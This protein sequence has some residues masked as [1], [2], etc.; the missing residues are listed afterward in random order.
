M[1]NLAESLSVRDQRQPG[2]FHVDNEI[3]DQYG[4]KLGAYGVAVYCVLSRHAKR[5]DERVNLS[6]RDVAALLGISQDRVR[7]SLADLAEAGLIDLQ[8]PT[9]PAQGSISAIT[10][11]NVKPNR[12]P[13]VQSSPSDRTPHVQLRPS[14]ERH[15]FGSGHEPNATRSPYKEEKTNTETKTKLPPINAPRIEI[16]QGPKFS[17][18]AGDFQT[19]IQRKLERAG[20]EVKREYGIWHGDRYARIDLKAKRGEETISIECDWKSPRDK[21]LEKL[22]MDSGATRRLVVLR[23]PTADFCNVPCFDDLIA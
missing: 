16:L 10:L 4:Q 15:T 1:A 21:S 6:A 14:T 11:L 13:H 3:I 18:G 17:E 9:R 12:T 19:F 7:K 20:F 23:E 2:W 8:A 22:A 5:G